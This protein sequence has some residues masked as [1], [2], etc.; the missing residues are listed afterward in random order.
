[1]A[2]RDRNE[3]FNREGYYGTADRD[4]DYGWRNQ[5]GG[6]YDRDYDYD[7]R[8]QYRGTYNRDYE[9]GR[10]GYGGIYDRDYDYGRRG[11][12]GTYDRDYERGWRGQSGGGYDQGYDYGWQGRSEPTWTYTEAWWIPGPQTGRGPR[13]Y[14]RSDDRIRED[15]NDRLMQHGQIDASDID[16]RVQNCEVTLTGTVNSRQEKRMA[17]DTAE[18]VWGVKE[19]HNQLRVKQGQ[20][21][22]QNQSNQQGQ[23]SQQRQSMPTQKS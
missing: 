14:R 11:Y 7:W 12:G 13:S 18:A 8:G 23:S 16:V 19:V 3:R 10:R 21:N 1:M 20:Q 2:D 4:Y 9:Y 22:G 17:E 5:F 15:V 6:T